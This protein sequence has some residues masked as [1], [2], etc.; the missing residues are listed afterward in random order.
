[1]ELYIV[2]QGNVYVKRRKKKKMVC[3][4]EMI[5]KGKEI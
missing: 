5:F 3:W 1:V 2:G 4:I